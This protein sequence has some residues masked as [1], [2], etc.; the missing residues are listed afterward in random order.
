MVIVVLR[1]CLVEIWDENYGAFVGK[2]GEGVACV[3]FDRAGEHICDLSDFPLDLCLCLSL[4]FARSVSDG[5]YR[6]LWHFS[7]RY[8]LP[9]G[10]NYFRQHRFVLRTA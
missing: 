2:E 3:V 7:S 6:M 1:G 9:F 8:G 10:R 4:L 5:S